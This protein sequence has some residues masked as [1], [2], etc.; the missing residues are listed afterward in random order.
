MKKVLSFVLMGILTFAGSFALIVG[1]KQ[2]WADIQSLPQTT[3]P[4]ASDIVQLFD[5]STGNMI[6]V[7]WSFMS[8]NMLQ[9][10]NWVGLSTT[11]GAINWNYI[12]ATP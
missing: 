1:P 5:A 7:N 9:G 3:V 2:A 10:V 4:A 11:T 6:G 8:R 12:G